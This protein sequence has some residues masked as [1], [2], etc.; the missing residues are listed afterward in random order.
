[1][2]TQFDDDDELKPLKPWQIGIVYFVLA[3]GSCTVLYLIFSLLK[4]KS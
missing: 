3:M 4:N 2:H 1:M